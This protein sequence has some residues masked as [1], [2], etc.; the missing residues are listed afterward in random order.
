MSFGDGLLGLHP[1][2]RDLLEI[3]RVAF[4][5]YRGLMLITGTRAMQ[6][7]TGLFVVVAVYALAWVLKLTM[8]TFLLGLMFTYGLV[9]VLIVFQPEVRAALA[10]IGRSPISRFARRLDQADAAGVIADAAMRLAA[11][12]TGALIAVARDV[13]LRSYLESGTELQA[14]VSPDLLGAIFAVTSPLH[15]GAVIVRRDTIIGAGCILPLSQ[16]PLSDRSLGTRH[17]AAIG[18]SEETDALVL[19]VSEETGTVSVAEDGQLVRD[20]TEAMLR[21]MLSGREWRRASAD[22][23]RRPAD[24]G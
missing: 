13:S 21:N 14:Q 3:A 9:A 24:G 17:R 1:G 22:G 2:W 7:L 16:K 8:I 4:V 18:L 6:I 10:T 20:V 23:G 19:V 11:R 5:F 12:G 15:D